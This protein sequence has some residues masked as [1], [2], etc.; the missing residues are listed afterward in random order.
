MT[1]ADAR[2]WHVQRRAELSRL[3]ERHTTVD[4]LDALQR[5]AGHEFDTGLWAQH[6]RR[7]QQVRA[8][9]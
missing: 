1:D 3:I 8:G 5:A 7:V 4:A 6:A 9:K 2:L